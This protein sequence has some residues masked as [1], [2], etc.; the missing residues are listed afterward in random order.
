VRPNLVV[1]GAMK[2]ATT[3]LHY[4]LGLHPDIKM[5]AEKELHFFVAERNWPRGLAWYERQFAGREAVHG[6]SSTTYARFPHY[7]GVAARMHALLPAAKLIYVV[8]D[9]VDR[10]VSQYVHE[11]AAGR[12]DRPLAEALTAPSPNAYLDLSRY[13]LQ[14]AQYLPYYPRER[15][16]VLTAEDLGARRAEV[17]RRTFAFLGVGD[18]FDDPRF[19]A[20]KHV[21]AAK[22]RLSARGMRLSRLRAWSLLG[23]P[24]PPALRR[25]AGRLLSHPF[26]SPVEAPAIPPDL[27]RRLQDALGADLERFHLLTGHPVDAWLR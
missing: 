26:S 7:S 18:T 9:P 5:A 1:I 23:R 3:S 6:E 12:E 8:R 27:R 24:L 25:L 22:R 17:L 16:L 10:A 13:G 19:A 11:Y 15:V 20:V 21:S 2:C 4:Y 14:I